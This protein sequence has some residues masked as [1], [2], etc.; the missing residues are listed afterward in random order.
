VVKFNIEGY[1]FEIWI[2]F[3]RYYYLNK[4]KECVEIKLPSKI[5]ELDINISQNMPDYIY[6]L[7]KTLFLYQN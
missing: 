4:Y 5:E 3:N 6:R 2:H 1:S 7:L